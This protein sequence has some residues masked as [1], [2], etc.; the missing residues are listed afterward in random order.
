MKIF[1]KQLW[2]AEKKESSIPIQSA[3]NSQ[4]SLQDS[5]KLQSSEMYSGW[6]AS[7]VK[8]IAE[9][10]ARI[11]LVLYRRSGKKIEVIEEHPALDLLEY[12]NEFFTK[13]T[14]FERL[15]S[16]LE[17][18]GNEYWYLERKGKSGQIIAIYPLNPDAI[19][20]VK[21]DFYV[22]YY[23]YRVNGKE[24]KL[25]PEQVIHFKTYN[26][27]SD[28]VGLS[29]IESARVI[30]ETDVFSREYNR[31]FYYNDATPGG[32]LTHPD[33]LDKTSADDIKEKWNESYGGY[34]RAFKTAVLSGGL[35]YTSI[36]PKHSD[37]Q[38][39]EQSKLNRD[40]ILAMFRVPKNILAV[41]EDVNYASAKTGNYVFSLRNI[42]PKMHRIVDTLNKFF[43][44]LFEDGDIWFGFKSP[45]QEDIL[46]L[47][48]VNQILFA[49]G[50][51][52]MNEWRQRSGL[53]PIENGD[54]VFLPFSL[55]PYGKPVQ[56]KTQEVATSLTKLSHEIKDSVLTQLHLHKLENTNNTKEISPEASHK[57]EPGDEKS[58]KRFQLRMDPHSFED[59]GQKINGMMRVREEPYVKK[60]QTIMN[61]LF[62]DQR[63]EAIVNLRSYMKKGGK[64]IKAKLPEFIDVAKQ[65]KITIDLFKPL[66]E[67]F[68]NKEGQTAFASLG[69]KAEDFDIAAPNVRKYLEA[70]VKKFANEVTTNTSTMIRQQ[71]ADGLES[72]EGVQAITSR[73][74]DLAGLSETRS[75]L[76]A[77]TEIHRAQG[78]A[79]IQAWEQSNVVVAKI[80]YTALDER[81]CVEC[82]LMHGKEVDLGDAFVSV[83]DLREMGYQNY[84]GAVEIA[85]LHPRCR[86]SIIPVVKGQDS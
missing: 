81:V 85:Q 67:E 55:S 86:C 13:F 27:F 49:N 35:T 71:I 18:K 77:I 28:I 33:E 7:C 50:Q 57:D 76:I 48:Q 17:L 83:S 29:T 43:L 82:S 61:K 20:P 47:T 72:G 32:V 65:V 63:E 68:L 2:G 84:D 21:G 12:V 45:V 14:L 5:R 46:E 79:E 4:F 42:S 15:Q 52:T 78:N 66:M 75:E 26:P 25:K 11:E 34:K 69:L 62:A 53:L 70:S 10:V 58:N 51:L 6:V 3:Y 30:I 9:E 54:Q 1:G 59:L 73:I 19:T 39:I 16:N 23:S 38:Y 36:T 22:K 74:S 60:A 80:W 64:A 40:D 8:A 56:Q 24:I 31:R 41:L 37:M 44:P